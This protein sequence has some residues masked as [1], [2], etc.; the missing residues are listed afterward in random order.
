MCCNCSWHLLLLC[1]GG[2]GSSFLSFTYGF[3]L[4]VAVFTI[5]A[6]LGASSRARIAA[7]LEHDV[8]AGKQGSLV[9]GDSTKRYKPKGTNH[10][11]NWKAL[12][13][14]NVRAE[15]CWENEKDEY[16]SSKMCKKYVK[17][18]QIDKLWPKECHAAHMKSFACRP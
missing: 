17:M 3:T 2:W 4:Y 15:N 16:W 8:V 18:C 14:P 10:A 11:F 12:E 13:D 1:G 7:E 5:K 9:V 6:F